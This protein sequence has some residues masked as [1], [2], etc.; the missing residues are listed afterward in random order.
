MLQLPGMQIGFQ[1]FDILDTAIFFFL[2]TT[3]Y[4][5]KKC[6]RPPVI[7]IRKHK[8]FVFQNVFETKIYWI[9]VFY[10]Q[11][12]DGELDFSER[13]ENNQA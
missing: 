10:T 11:I 8:Y 9:N 12:W 1:N 5:F 7:K 3:I 6:I 4:S 2:S 13:S